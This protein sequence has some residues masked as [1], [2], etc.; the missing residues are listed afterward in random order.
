MIEAA[1]GCSLKTKLEIWIALELELNVL[2]TYKITDSLPLMTFSSVMSYVSSLTEPNE[3]I[4]ATTLPAIVVKVSFAP[5]T[6]VS[7]TSVA[8]DCIPASVKPIFQ[9]D[10]PEGLAGLH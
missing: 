3:E 7:A 9:V 10:P 2:W 1:S 8:K 5:S 4:L 6:N